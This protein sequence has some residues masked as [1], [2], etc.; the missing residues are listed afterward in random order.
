MRKGEAAMEYGALHGLKVRDYEYPGEDNAFALLKKVPFLDQAVSAYLKLNAQAGI[1]P[2]IH[3]DCFRITE[4]TCP[5]VYR[6][7]ET[8]LRR[9]DMPEAYPLYAKSEFEFN[10]F[11]MG[12][13]P[14]IVV[15]SSMLNNFRPEELQYV[16]GHELGHIKSGHVVY[17]NM[18][19]QLQA[20]IAQ[21]PVIG[22]EAAV[23]LY[24]ALHQW[25]RMQEC[26]ADRAGV[27]AAGS[28][29]AGIRALG[30]LMGTDERLPLIRFTEE[31]ILRQNDAFEEASEDFVT[32]VICL[33]QVAHSSHPWTVTRVK[34][35]REWEESGGFREVVGKYA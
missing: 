16:I 35:L 27:L 33:A 25:Y 29:D 15:H 24:F 21:V 11:A 7:Y 20:L 34:R 17:A 9:L 3:G 4:G 23:G 13:E 10:A 18:A 2:A 1:L 31:D 28:V 22:Q 26:T 8:A 6:L 30:R 32:K 19:M 14:F 5:E 12:G